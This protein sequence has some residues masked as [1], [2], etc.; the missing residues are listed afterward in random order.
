MV[1]LMRQAKEYFSGD[2]TLCRDNESCIR[3]AD[4]IVTCTN[5]QEPVVALDWFT[6][7]AFGVGIEGRPCIALTSSS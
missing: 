6:E 1:A 7:G 5:G 2:V 3:N 4:I